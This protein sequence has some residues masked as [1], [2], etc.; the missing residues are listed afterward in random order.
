MELET[1]LVVA[2]SVF[3]PRL[4]IQLTSEPLAVHL[5]QQWGSRL[6]SMVC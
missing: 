2:Q 3:L 1:G 5:T 4:L 6:R